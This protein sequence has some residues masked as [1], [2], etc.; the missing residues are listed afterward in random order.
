MKKIASKALAGGSEE[1]DMDAV[2]TD[3]TGRSVFIIQGKFRKEVGKK[4]RED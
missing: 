4:L 1:K 3:E 2:I